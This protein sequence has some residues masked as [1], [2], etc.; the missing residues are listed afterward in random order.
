MAGLIEKL[1]ERL[2]LKACIDESES[3]STGAAH[4]LIYGCWPF[5]TFRLCHFHCPAPKGSGPPSQKLPSRRARRGMELEA[6][7]RRRKEEVRVRLHCCLPSTQPELSSYPF[8]VLCFDTTVGLTFAPFRHSIREY[9]PD[10]RRHLCT[11]TATVRAAPGTG[12]SR[13]VCAVSYTHLTLP[14]T[15]YV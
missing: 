10:F 7:R 6:W 12:E 1:S 8:G 11:T 5:S 14:T 13:S 3:I 9:C 2:K 4:V 15:P